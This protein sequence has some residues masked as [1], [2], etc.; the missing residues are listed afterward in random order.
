VSNLLWHRSS[1]KK[2]T[3]ILLC[4]GAVAPGLGKNR[5][6]LNPAEK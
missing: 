5:P 1:G 2:K 4:F 6:F 3:E